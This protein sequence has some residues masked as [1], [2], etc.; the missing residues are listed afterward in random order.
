MIDLLIHNCDI[1]Q[2]ES[3]DASPP[4]TRLLVSQD[5]LIQGQRILAV[6][7]ATLQDRA[8]QYNRPG[9]VEPSPARE[10]IQASGL[11]AIPGLINTHAHVPMVLFRGLVEDV[12]IAS[13]FNDYIWPLEANLTPEDIYWGALL[14]LAE[15]IE[16]GVTAVADHYFFMDQV[17]EAIMQAGMRANLAWAVFAH[18]G[19][20]KLDQ[21]CAFIQRWQG[22]ADGRITTWLG[23]HAPYTTGPDFLKLCAKR[24]KELKVGIHTHVSET[25]EQ[26]QLSLE[27]HGITPIQM[28]AE[29]GILEQPTILAHCLYPAESDFALLAAAPVGIAHAPKTYLKLGMG[30]APVLRYIQEG[31]PVGLAS[32]GAVSSNTLDL[33]EQLRLMVLVQK[34][35]AR[36]STAMPVGLALE[37]A[38]HGGA[39]VLHLNHELGDIAPGKLADLVLLD[40][41]G[42]HTFPRLDPAANL[43]FSARAADV[44]TVICDGKILLQDGRLLTIDKEQVKR[45]VAARL[46]RL[47]Q[48]IPG[49]RIASYPA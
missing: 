8:V 47:N 23:P 7:P 5:I 26:V 31:I 19:V 16:A 45:E 21:T 11:L 3:G 18:E 44:H 35:T 15:M 10:T 20:E 27:Q 42:L 46:Q 30:S 13:W 40:Q 24:A 17:A 28:L 41:S 49:R 6:Q 9:S 29:A 12:P 33:L 48:R 2:V 38:F 22:G 32:D 43:V 4:P 14:G 1:L 37:I 34:S 39:R 25:A 36:D